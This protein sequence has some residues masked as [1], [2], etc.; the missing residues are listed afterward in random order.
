MLILHIFA[1]IG[2]DIVCVLGDTMDELWLFVA[3]CLRDP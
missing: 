2:F 3:S 1:C